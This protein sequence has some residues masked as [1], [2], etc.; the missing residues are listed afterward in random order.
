[1]QAFSFSYEAVTKTNYNQ[2]LN[3]PDIFRI[4]LCTFIEKYFWRKKF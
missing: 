4:Y 1:M 3:S 2:S